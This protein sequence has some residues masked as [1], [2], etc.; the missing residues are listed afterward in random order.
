MIGHT[1][2]KVMF[3]ADNQSVDSTDADVIYVACSEGTTNEGWQDSD[4]EDDHEE[5]INEVEVEHDQQLCIRILEQYR[6]YLLPAS[7]T[8]QSPSQSTVSS[9]SLAD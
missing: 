4:S 2:D 1:I 5:E 9:V 8:S 7:R 6:Q 3:N